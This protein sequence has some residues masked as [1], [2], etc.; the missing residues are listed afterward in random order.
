[1]IKKLIITSLF[2][3][4]SCIASAYDMKNIYLKANI[5]ASKLNSAKE[6]KQ[7]INFNAKQHAKISPSIGL[8]VGYNLPDNNIRAEI[9]AHIHSPYFDMSSSTLEYTDSDSNLQKVGA[10]FTKRKA[11]IKTLMP[12]IYYS[13]FSKEDYDIFVGGG[14]GI[15]RIKE[16]VHII[17]TSNHI[18]QGLIN[19]LL[20]ETESSTT[21]VRNNLAYMLSVGTAVKL[22]ENVSVEFA[23]NWRDFGKTKPISISNDETPKKNRYKGHDFTLGLR[24]AI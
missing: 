20:V 8:A 3:L 6:V 15:A 9:N 12:S 11:N 14:I 19:P 1:M 18:Q 23:Y 16:K 21:K 22:Q 24:L 17:T 7:L 10:M 2:L 5:G 13:V 4:N